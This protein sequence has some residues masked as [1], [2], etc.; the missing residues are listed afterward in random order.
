MIGFVGM[1]VAPSASYEVLIV[2]GLLMIWSGVALLV[3]YR[4]AISRWLETLTVMPR[5]RLSPRA[6]A[7][8]TGACTGLFGLVIALGSIAM[9]I[10]GA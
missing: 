7:K 5:S 9:L 10:T 1:T 2:T 6:F 4:N 8:F 3:D